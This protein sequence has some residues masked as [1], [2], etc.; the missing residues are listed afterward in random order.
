MTADAEVKSLP[1][2]PEAEQAL[3]GSLLVDP[4]ALLRIA[5]SRL[6]PEDL[7]DL[8]HRLILTAIR[9]MAGRRLPADVVSV[10]EF[11]RDRQQD[12]HAGGLA[13]I[14]A[15]S[16]CVASSTNVSRYAD[17]VIDKARRRAILAAL[18]RAGSIANSPGE[19]GEVLDRVES[20]VAGLRQDRGRT[21]FRR[22]GELFTERAAHWEGLQAG[23]A[24][25]GVS[26][27]LPVLDSVLSGGCH[28]GHVITIGARPSVG[29]T[30]L[31]AQI[32]GYVAMQGGPTLIISAEMPGAEL[33]D[34]SAANLTGVPLER[35]KTG[36]FREGDWGLVSDA[37]ESMLHAPLYVEE[38]AGVTMLD[39]RSSA[40]RVVQAHGRIALIVVDY[41]Q[42]LQT[43][44]NFTTRHHAIES[45][46]RG[47]KVLAKELGA[48]VLL[49]AQL[50][51]ASTDDEPEL[52][53]LKESGAIEEDADAVLLLHA[54]GPAPEGG[55]LV[56]VKVAKNR[57]GRRGRFGF[58]F[59]GSTQRWQGSAGDVRRQ[60]GGSAT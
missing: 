41:L 57:H 28:P 58:A 35:F 38:R 49:L 22:A 39:I 33:I 20:L 11:L 25:P 12:E 13:Y 3:L 14:N 9:D 43:P 24:L 23:T 6:Q 44:G 40:R 30:S 2:A 27:G 50:N 48:T 15:L 19:V 37:T 45:L 7:F 5:D 47:M 51:R 18:D 59:D 26:T 34:R 1:W 32:A 8:R 56:L 4:D 55:L 29:K 36:G 53:H 60:R 46:S 21:T 31:A 16:T 42:L 52:H 10:F 17:V 54:L